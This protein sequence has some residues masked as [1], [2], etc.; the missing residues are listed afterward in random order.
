MINYWDR[1]GGMCLKANRFDERFMGFEELV[2]RSPYRFLFCLERIHEHFPKKKVS[3]LDVGCNQGIL[4]KRCQLEGWEA[5]G[6]DIDP[7]IIPVC[8]K[9]TGARLWQMLENVD[10]K[11]DVVT[12]VSVVEHVEDY[13]QFIKGMWKRVDKGGILI[14]IVPIGKELDSP[15][16]FHWFNFYDVLEF[17]EI[18][19]PEPKD[20]HIYMINKWVKDFTKV[21]EFGLVIFKNV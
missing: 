2:K 8:K 1:Y 3:V 4:I 6:V 11:Y 18:L 16:H 5:D 13:K 10:R 19:R 20:Y 15:D 21:N 12:A 7:D 9:N 14:I 17:A